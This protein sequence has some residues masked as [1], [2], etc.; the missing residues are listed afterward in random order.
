MNSDSSCEL[1]LRSHE[2][3]QQGAQEASLMAEQR[4]TAA[5]RIR[6]VNPYIEISA[7]RAKALKPGWRRPLP[8]LVRIGGI[9][10]DPWRT[11]LMPAGDGDFYLYL[12]EQMRR[13]SNC[14]VG[15]RVEVQ[16]RVDHHYT[17]GPIHSMPAWFSD[18]LKASA[19]ALRNW[20][21]LVPSRQKEILRYFASLKSDA[22]RARNVDRAMR[23]LL[24]QRER[25]MAR[26]W[27][28]GR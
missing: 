7:S 23:V 21:K 2:R 27:K 3:A 16:L 4:F 1:I 10:R 22:A 13:A 15:N 6:G 8:V 25:F 14:G 26:S 5:I 24:G 18:R 9:P 11:N 20:N 28:D 12:H 19:T 17:G